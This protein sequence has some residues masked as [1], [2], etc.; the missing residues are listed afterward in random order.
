MMKVAG[1]DRYDLVNTPMADGATFTIW[2]AGCTHKCNGCQNMELWDSNAGKDF[3]CYEL[4]N[5]IVKGT[6]QT[7]I[8]TVTLLGGEPLQQDI[9]D[10]EL[11]CHMLKDAG[12]EIWLYTGYEIH[13]VPQLVLRYIDHIKCGRYD[14]NLRVEGRFPITTNQKVYHKDECGDMILQQ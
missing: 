12:Y 1:F 2:F 14:E 4:F 7:N 9:G 8:H 5:T 6:E 11:L 13:E 3:S 10:I